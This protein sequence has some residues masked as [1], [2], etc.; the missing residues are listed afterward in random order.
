M[1]EMEGLGEE[2]MQWSFLDECMGVVYGLYRLM[3]ID[4]IIALRCMSTSYRRE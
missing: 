2:I 3:I 1:V 4:Y